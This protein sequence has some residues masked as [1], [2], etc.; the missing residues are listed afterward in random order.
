MWTKT[1][2]VSLSA[3]VALTGCAGTPAGP[4][5][6]V[7]PAAH[8][9]FEVFQQEQAYCKQ[10]ATDQ[11]RGEAESANEMALG[12]TLLGSA[13]GAGLG[14]AIGGGRGAGV[15]AAGGGLF[16]TAIGAGN[17]E[18]GQG[19][20]QQQY[21]NAYGQCMYAKGNQVVQPQP[22]AVIVT[23]PPAVYYAPPPTVYYA[24]APY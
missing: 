21:D 17:S 9:P 4:S 2:A 10:Y 7:L 23:P 1:L 22:R 16:G 6:Q 5:I 18:K 12:T 14:A 24:P 13:L 11:V 8:K 20:I 3:V 19:G 15:G